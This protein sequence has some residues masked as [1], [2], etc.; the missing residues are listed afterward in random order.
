MVGCKVLVCFRKPPLVSPEKFY[1]SVVVN[2]AIKTSDTGKRTIVYDLPK[3]NNLNIM[4][5]YPSWFLQELFSNPFPGLP[6]LSSVKY[7]LVFSQ[8]LKDMQI[9]SIVKLLSLC[10]KFVSVCYGC[11]NSFWFIGNDGWTHFK[12]LEIKDLEVKDSKESLSRII[13]VVFISF[14]KIFYSWHI[15]TFVMEFF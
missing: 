11:G 9:D 10:Y 13:K 2:T 15:Q 14:K 6:S 5:P 3:T 12:N 1:S 8:P 7:Y 4:K